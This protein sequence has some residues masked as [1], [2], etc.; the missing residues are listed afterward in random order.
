MDE[1]AG[2]AKLLLH[3]AGEFSR[4]P[5]GKGK[6]IGKA[7]I[8]SLPRVPFRAADPE[9]VQEKIDVLLDRQVL[10]EAE[11]LGHVADPVLDGRPVGNDVQTVDHDPARR[12]L[13]HRRRHPQQG[14]LPRSV[15]ADQ[16]IDRPPFDRKRDVA[17]RLVLAET[18]GNPFDPDERIRCLV[19]FGSRRSG[20][21]RF[22]VTRHRR[23][24]LT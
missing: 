2:Q 9:D 24:S 14:R 3:P 23:A 13:E 8:E 17:N 10:V 18:A 1:N 6:E 11:T 7:E 20:N 16:T 21:R 5:V 19:P 22:S 4:R 12:G 15:R